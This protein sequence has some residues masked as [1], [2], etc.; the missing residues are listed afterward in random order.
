MIRNGSKNVPLLLW[1]VMYML[2]SARRDVC[3]CLCIFVDAISSIFIWF[4][5]YFM[6]MCFRYLELSRAAAAAAYYV[7]K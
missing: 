2:L 6:N 7:A 4:F 5:V 1:L 3:V